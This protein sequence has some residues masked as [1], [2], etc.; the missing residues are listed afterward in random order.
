MEGSTLKI[1]D[2]LYLDRYVSDET[3]HLIII[4][5]DVC[6]RCELKPC[7]NTCPAH[8]YQWEGDRLSV[9]Y[10]GCLEDGACRI[11]CPYGNIDWRYP[12]GGFGVSYK[13]G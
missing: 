7:I 8:V 6:A 3:S 5:Q 1:E 13:Y 2:K 10:E 12:R 9:A 4:D 11:V